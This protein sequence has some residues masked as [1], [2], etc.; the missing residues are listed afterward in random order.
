MV[1]WHSRA[2]TPQLA[3][4][5]NHLPRIAVDESSLYL[6]K[7]EAAPE[8]VKTCSSGKKCRKLGMIQICSPFWALGI[9]MGLQAPF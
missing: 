1:V 2:R 6:Y 3:T 7:M 4:R 5:S 9:G 8:N